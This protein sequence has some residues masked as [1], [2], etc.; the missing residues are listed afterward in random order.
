[1][2]ATQADTYAFLAA[3]QQIGMELVRDAFWDGRQ[4]RCTW[5]GHAMDP[6]EGKYTSVFRAFGNDLYNGSSGIAL[7][8]AALHTAQPDP[9]LEKTVAGAMQHT[10]SL[11]P[12][13]P[14]FGFYGG[15]AGIAASLITTGERLARKEWIGQGLDVLTAIGKAE[16][17]TYDIDIISGMA[18]TIPCLLDAAARY[19]K[20]KL[21]DIARHLGEALVKRAYRNQQGWSW[22]TIAGS[23][24]LTGYSHGTAG[25]A[26]SLLQL[27]TVTQDAQF[28]EAATGGFQ[29]EQ[30]HYD[31]SQQNWPDFRENF[32]RAADGRYN[33]GLAWCHG[34]P[35][36]ALSRLRTMELKDDPAA[37]QT[38]EVALNTTLH[39]T[40]TL[41]SQP[42]YATNYSL[43]HGI[44]GNADILLQSGRTED[45]EAAI[46]AG[47]AGIQKYASPRLPWPSGIQDN[48]PTPGLMMGIAGTG[49]FYLRLYDA[50][51]FNTLLLAGLPATGK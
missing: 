16:P 15:K 8:L 43:C 13:S 37:R 30:T 21:L 32:P 6:V 19:E 27:Y 29:Y 20:E 33:C 47:I 4:E 35:G 14:D 2:T 44:A 34:A 9:L 39:N 18:G 48:K 17:Q 10:I 31:A 12:G 3:A 5:L 24:N 1:M 7:F 51:S 40:R 36:I 45:R 11:L 22:S 50:A 23:G 28:L 25:I 41:L 49:Y 26:V 46:A 42:G 38:A